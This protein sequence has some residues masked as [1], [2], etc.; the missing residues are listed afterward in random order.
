EVGPA[1]VDGHLAVGR[2]G[3]D[4][5]AELGEEGRSLGVVSGHLK[6]GLR[7]GEILCFDRGVGHCRSSLDPRLAWSAAIGGRSVLRGV[8]YFCGCLPNR[9]RR[10]RL[11]SD[12]VIGRASLAMS[13]TPTPARGRRWP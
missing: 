2:H 5:K 12:S 6:G 9:R 7:G 1:L 3:H 11:R 8:G 13:I 10:S 4:A